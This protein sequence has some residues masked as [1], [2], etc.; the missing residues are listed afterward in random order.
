MFA[1][2]VG[3]MERA[4][5][6]VLGVGLIAYGGFFMGETDIFVTLAGACVI[7]TG[8]FGYCPA[9]ALAGRSRP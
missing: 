8:M 2:N 6:L 5:R 3:K 4:I 9:C 1:A 7:L